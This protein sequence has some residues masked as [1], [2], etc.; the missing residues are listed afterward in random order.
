MLTYVDRMQF[1]VHNRGI[2]PQ[3]GVDVLRSRWNKF[4]SFKTRAL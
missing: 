4:A 1:A 3:E 2:E